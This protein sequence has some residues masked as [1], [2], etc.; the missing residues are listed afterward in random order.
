MYRIALVTVSLQHYRLSFYEKLTKSNP[1]MHWTIYHGIHD[2]DDG[3]P[4][5]EGV[6]G[7]PNQRFREIKKKFGPFSIVYNKGLNSMIRRSD[8]DVLIMPGMAGNISNRMIIYWARRKGKKVIMWTCGW[9]PGLAKGFL[10]SFKNHFVSSFFRK[11]DF[12][13]TYSNKANKYTELMGVP[14]KNI[15]TCYNGIEIDNLLET[16]GKV[17][18]NSAILRKE[19]NLPGNVTFLYVGG[20]IP[21]K[22]IDLLIDG[23]IGLRNKHPNIKLLIIGDGPGKKELLE[24]LEKVN[25]NHILYLG[26]I[27]DKVDEYFAAAD[28]LVLPGVGGLALNQAMFWGKLCIVSEADGTEDDLVIDGETG[29]RFEKGNLVSLREAMEKMVLL[30]PLKHDKMSKTAK[31][32]ILEKSNT[33]NM[34]NIFI[35]TLNKLLN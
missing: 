1:D 31:K 13:L 27:V 14:S 10:L 22:R 16:E 6:I 33:N 23:F 28:C 17:I 12:H 4:A 7:F 2:K 5:Y 30:D 9:E 35:E 34:V 25:D 19:F 8:P 3:R 24:I 15:Q 11:A 18:E 29:F 20:L 21:E 32:I 26:R